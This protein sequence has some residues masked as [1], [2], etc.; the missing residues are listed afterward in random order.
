LAYLNV[1]IS[2]ANGQQ[3]KRASSSFSR[4]ISRVK[5]E[6]SSIYLKFPMV[7]LPSWRNVITVITLNSQ[8]S[9]TKDIHQFVARRQ[10][11]SLVLL[12]QLSCY[13]ARHEYHLIDNQ[14]TRDL[15]NQ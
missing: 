10:Q 5:D 6:K 15:K 12:V 11:R 2:V 9:I 7:E 3:L 4:E 8:T 14:I 13:A 1:A